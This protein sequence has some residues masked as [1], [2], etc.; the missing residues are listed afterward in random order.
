MN[1]PV[2]QQALRQRARRLEL[3][4][5]WAQRLR[6]GEV[7]EAGTLEWLHWC[8]ADPRN[9]QAFEQA[10]RI[11]QIA[12]EL[13]V[14]GQGAARG[15]TLPRI[16][17][18]SHPAGLRRP[19]L[20]APPSQPRRRSRWRPAVA[21]AAA[22]L[23]TVAG[24]A[25]WQ[26]RGL[27]PVWPQRIADQDAVTAPARLVHQT[28]LSDGSRIE[29]AARSRIAV[30]YS[31]RERRLQ[32]RDGEAYFAV[33]PEPQRPFIVDIGDVRVRA[34][35]TEFNI[36]HSAGRIVVTVASGLVDVYRMGSEALRLGAGERVIWDPGTPELEVVRRINVSA[37]PSW[38]SGRLEYTDEPLSAVIADFNR[39]APRRAVIRSAAVEQLRFS[40]TL[41]TDISEDW[42]RT[43]PRLFPVSVRLHGD[44]YVIDAAPGTQVISRQ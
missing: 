30:R 39:Y 20:M 35:G 6:D 38:R 10:Q 26:A 22:V 28:R 15:S 43:L 24:T 14:A 40:G 12:G 23:I 37:P 33:E 21:M 44:I 4:A 18:T 13:G 25:A 19:R 34:I 11:W 5:D 3:A 36:R 31:E 42:L 29:L 41:L 1:A 27:A 2:D 7:D 32:L 16:A 8:E 17:A 9:Q